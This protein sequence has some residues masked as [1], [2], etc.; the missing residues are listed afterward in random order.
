M[1]FL[2]CTIRLVFSD[3]SGQ[4]LDGFSWNLGHILVPCQSTNSLLLS[5][6]P[7]LQ[8]TDTGSSVVAE[9]K[10]A[11]ALAA[12][13]TGQVHALS[14]GAACTQSLSAL[15]DIC[16]EGRRKRVR[17]VLYEQQR[18][19][20][21]MCICECK[22]IIKGNYGVFSTYTSYVC[23]LVCEVPSH[24]DSRQHSHVHYAIRK[25]KTTHG[26]CDQKRDADARPWEPG[27]SPG[28]SYCRQQRRQTC[29]WANDR[30]RSSSEHWK[31]LLSR[32]IKREEE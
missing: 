23:L 15:I 5:T 20:Y 10:A 3:V 9:L 27:Q 22:A 24:L 6:F 19:T 12:V 31:S 29:C 30:T 17:Q 25:T 4:L 1:T 11:L 2:Y 26:L 14:V 16:R 18:A 7:S 28:L 13:A 8:L 32:I 21:C